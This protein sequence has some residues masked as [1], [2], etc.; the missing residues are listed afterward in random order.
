MKLSE[1]R[2][3]KEEILN[4]RQ[5]DELDQAAELLIE[6]LYQMYEGDWDDIQMTLEHHDALEG[7]WADLESEMWKIFKRRRRQKR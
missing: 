6:H 5:K 7:L 3:L 1:V 2:K 4:E